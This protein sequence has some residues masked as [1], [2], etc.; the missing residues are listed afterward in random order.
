M[1]LKVFYIF[2]LCGI[3]FAKVS[4]GESVITLKQ[5]HNTAFRKPGNVSH[6]GLPLSMAQRK[7]KARAT[8]PCLEYFSQFT[9]IRF[10]SFRN[11]KVCAGKS[12][13]ICLVAFI[14]GKRGPPETT[15]SFLT[16]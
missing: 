7:L 3:I 15:P 5:A 16:V 4:K 1:G 8:E 2:F 9:V 11:C 6:H 10:F 12:V 14:P 13:S